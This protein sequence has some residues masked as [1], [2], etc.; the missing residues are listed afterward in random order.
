MRR[1]KKTDVIIGAIT[2]GL[3]ISVYIGT[4]S[5]PTEQFASPGVPRPSFLPRIL[6]GGLGL[7][8]ILLIIS[9]IMA[10]PE[11]SQPTNWRNVFKVVAAMALITAYIVVMPR[12]DFF[13]VTPFLI[14][15][16]SVIMGERSWKW[17]LATV[18][19]FELMAYFVFF[20]GLG[21]FFPT[22]IFY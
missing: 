22:K 9:C 6:A 17:I 18:V 8:S 4:L 5:F 14:A 11:A 7:F 19:L 2:L 20:K 15:P 13:I 1:V 12:I 16:I 21:V 10:K 3:A